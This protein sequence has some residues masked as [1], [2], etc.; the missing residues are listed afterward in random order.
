MVWGNQ[1]ISGNFGSCSSRSRL[2]IPVMMMSRCRNRE[3]R[4][5]FSDETIYMKKR[6]AS[7]CY[8]TGPPPLFLSLSTVNSPGPKVLMIWF[9]NSV[10]ATATNN[11]GHK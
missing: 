6:P 7:H 11:T 10:T 2:F 4:H 1:I 9:F 3:V 5:F 8:T